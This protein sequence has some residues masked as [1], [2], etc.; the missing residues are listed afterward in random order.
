MS[1]YTIR[2]S[3]QAHIDIENLHFYIFETCKSPMTSKRYIEG[4]YHKI[5]SLSHSAESHPISSLKSILLYGYNARRINFKKMAIIYTVHQR[6]VLIRRVIP[7][8]LI[9]EL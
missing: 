4:I 9:A 7:G 8:A 3:E 1:S 6:T 5:K 2:T